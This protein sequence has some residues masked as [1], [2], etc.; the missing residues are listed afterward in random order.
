MLN[1]QRRQ[2]GNGAGGVARAEARIMLLRRADE[3]MPV[4]VIATRGS[5]YDKIVSNLQEAKAREGRPV[6]IDRGRD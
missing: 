3:H 6:P 5:H 4:V 2:T 1:R